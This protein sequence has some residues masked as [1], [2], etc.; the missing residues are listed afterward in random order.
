MSNAKYNDLEDACPNGRCASDQQSKID[1]GR[2]YQTLANVGL[3]VG[4]VGVGAS[5]TL[6]VL[7]SSGPS[8]HKAARLELRAGLRSVELRG[9]FE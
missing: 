9:R 7:S 1:D 2:L 3:V 5:V 4:V 8:E 6:F